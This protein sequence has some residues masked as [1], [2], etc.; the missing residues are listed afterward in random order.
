MVT[1][2]A[3]NLTLEQV[4]QLLKLE[5][6]SDDLS[7]TELLALEPLTEF[8]QQEISQIQNDFRYYL[9]AGKVAEGQVKLLVLAPLLR[10][11]G[12]Y[13]P[14]IQI[15]LEQDIAEITI[16]DEDTTISGRLD[17]LAINRHKAPYFWVLVIEAKNSQ[18]DS[19]AGL[20]QLLTYAFE[21]LKQQESVWALT[22]NGVSY[23]FAYLQSA[24][25]SIY[26][27]LPEVNLIDRDRAIQLLQVLKAI[28]QI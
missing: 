24:N 11:A 4:H 20:P 15:L 5:E 9:N 23:R 3:K 18:I 22:T 17:L 6:D 10:L 26:Q 2:N 7:F 25:P 13:R 1:L 8:E 14:P 28:C 21:G 16:A 19:L 27:L 12:F